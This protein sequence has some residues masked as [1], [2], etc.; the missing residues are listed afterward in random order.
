[1]P[2]DA[3]LQRVVASFC[4]SRNDA[5]REPRRGLLRRCAPRNDGV[6][7]DRRPK[8]RLEP[9]DNARNRPGIG[10]PVTGFA[11]CSRLR[12]APSLRA[13]PRGRQAPGGKQS[14]PQDTSRAVSCF[15]ATL[16]A[17]TGSAVTVARK[18]GWN[19]L[20]TLETGPEL[21]APSQASR[22][23]RG[24]AQRRHCQPTPGSTSP[25]GKQSMPQDTSRAR[26]LLR[27]CAPRN[28]GIGSDRRPEIRLEP[29]DNARNRPGIGGPVTGFAFVRGFAQRRHCEPTRGPTSPGWEAIHAAGQEPRRVLLRRCAPRNDGI[30][31]DRR[32]EHPSHGAAWE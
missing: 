32:P 8:I 3:K 17:M 18:F 23:V 31:S 1:M 29:L 5:G 16:L 28:D 26:G 30:G 21:A 22:L 25:G 6:G 13:D 9:L 10:D 27:R 20:I 19:R 2:R 24:F 15:V 14:M 7:S 11:P 12:A 4:A